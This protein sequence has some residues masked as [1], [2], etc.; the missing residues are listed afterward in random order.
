MKKKIIRLIGISIFIVVLF[1]NFS[2]GFGTNNQTKTELKNLEALACY[3]I[4]SDTGGYMWS[5]CYP[6]IPYCYISGGYDFSG[7]ITF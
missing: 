2:L 5:C 4:E 3:T 1:F 7:T 6:W